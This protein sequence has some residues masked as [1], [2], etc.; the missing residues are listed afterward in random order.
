MK[1]KLLKSVL[2]F[3]AGRPGIEAKVSKDT[4]QGTWPL[5]VD[6]GIVGNHNNKVYFVHGKKVYALNGNAKS[7]Y[8]LIDKLWAKNDHGWHLP[9]GDLIKFGLNIPA[10]SE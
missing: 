2:A 1:N 10:Q 3:C 5:T 6:N 4:F 8:P 7:D 9:I